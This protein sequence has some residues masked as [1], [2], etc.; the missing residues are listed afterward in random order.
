MER[1]DTIVIGGGPA[2]LMAAVQASAQGE[3][4]LLVEK[5]DALGEKLLLAGRGR[6]NFTNGEE[7]MEVF[8]GRYGEKGRFLHSAF[9]RF[10]PAQTLEFFHKN[11]IR[12]VTE[13]GKRIFPV[14]EEN[15]EG[16]PPA[17][18]GQRIL[19]VLLMQCRMGGVRILRGNPVMSLKVRSGRVQRLI[20]AREELEAGRYIVATGGKSYP[21]TGSTGDGYRFAQSAG[22]TIVPTYPAL[23]PIR[24]QETWVKLAHGCNLRNVKLSVWVDRKKVEDHFG[25]ME[26]TNFG[27]SGPMVMELSSRVPEW[28]AAARESVQLSIDLKPALSR[29]TLRKRVARDFQER[30]SRRFFEAI[31][32][33]VPAPLVPMI[34][35]L[36]DIPSEKPA[37]YISVEEMEDLARLLK[38]IRLTVNGLWGFN[39]AV[40]T[41]GGVSLKEVDPATLRS[42]LCANLHFAG[43]VLDLNGPSGGFNLQVCWSTGWAAGVGGN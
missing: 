7:N 33:L 22:H 42:K 27:V 40:V 37:A 18:G 43:E 41:R 19:N 4:V 13:R 10:G 20:T 31:R 11:G 2:G 21:R 38:D 26:F 6:C 35:E 9:S 1:F 29:E 23:V 5:N 34:L 32:G 12:T 36:S 8:L 28:T 3:K 24:T 25:E 15:A 14:L 17:S 16:Q 30:G 39:H